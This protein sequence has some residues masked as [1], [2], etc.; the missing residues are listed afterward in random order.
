MDIASWG[1]TGN[2][3]ES[4]T[5]KQQHMTVIWNCSTLLASFNDEILLAFQRLEILT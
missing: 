1:F 3:N 2:I 4:T 5:E